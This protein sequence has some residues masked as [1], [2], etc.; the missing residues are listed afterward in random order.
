MLLKDTHNSKKSNIVK[1]FHIL[2]V[3][4]VMTKIVHLEV[5]TIIKSRTLKN[6]QRY[7][8]RIYLPSTFGEEQADPIFE[9]LHDQ[10][11]GHNFTLLTHSHSLNLMK[12]WQFLKSTTHVP[13][14]MKLYSNFLKKCINHILTIL[15]QYSFCSIGHL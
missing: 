11:K 8:V 12:Y 13:R 5:C 1:L 7:F 10:L 4:N 9:E 6:K 15:N 2:H 14:T 3:N